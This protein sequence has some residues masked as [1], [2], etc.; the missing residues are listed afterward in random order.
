MSAMSPVDPSGFGNIQGNLPWAGGAASGAGAFGGAAG[1]AYLGAYNSAVGMNE[2]N[3]NNIMAGYQ[4][5]IGAQTSAQQAI[6]SGYSNL[7]NTVLGNVQASYAGQGQQ[8]QN[9]AA[10]TQATG[11]QQLINRGLGNTTIQTSV[12]Q[13][14]NNQL[15]QQQQLLTG[16]EAGQMAQYGSQI[17]QAGLQN[18]EQGLQSTTGLSLDQLQFM[19]QANFAYP[20]AG[21]Y[22]QLAQTEAQTN[23]MKN[24]PLPG[25][26]P[27]GGGGP[28]VGYV[29][30]NPYYGGTGAGDMGGGSFSSGSVAP[31][32]GASWNT[33]NP[34]WAPQSQS[35][36]GQG[37][38]GALG[39]IAGASQQPLD[40]TQGYGNIYS[41][42]DTGGGGDF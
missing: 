18:Q 10:Q 17:G 14:V 24:H 36:G 27:Q 19:G 23:A 41:Q 16:Q 1:A 25:A 4:Q 5:T 32:A 31:A 34:A 15:A 40:Y 37:L 13:G 33:P 3:Y 29:P 28:Q 8:L 39:D 21:L 2:S 11:N 30:S 9:Q 7:Y 26:A 12:D 6:Q 20:N 38:F 35:G 42:G 22:A